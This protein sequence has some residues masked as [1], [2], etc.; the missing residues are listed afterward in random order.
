MDPATCHV[1]YVDKRATRERYENHE[2][3]ALPSIPSS[4]GHGQEIQEVRENLN[5]VLRSFDGGT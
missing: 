5:V 4:V 3:F 2:S 1:V